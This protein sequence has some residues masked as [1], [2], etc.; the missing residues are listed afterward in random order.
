MGFSKDF[1]MSEKPL[2]SFGIRELPPRQKAF[3]RN[4]DLS[5][6]IEF[7][8]LLADIACTRGSF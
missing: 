2:L 5:F 8:T 6:L 3:A 7:I 1:P 4:R